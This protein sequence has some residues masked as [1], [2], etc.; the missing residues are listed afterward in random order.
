MVH[1]WKACGSNP[2]RVRVPPPPPMRKKTESILSILAKFSLLIFFFLIVYYFYVG[3]GSIPWEGDSIDY[4]IPIAK[5]ILSGHIFNPTQYIYNFMQYC[6]G[7]NEIILSIFMFLKVPINIYNVV[8]LVV[9]YI[10]LKRLAKAFGLNK[11]IGTIFA[12]SI[13]ISHGVIRWV[14]AQTID[15]WMSTFFVLTLTLLQNPKKTLKYFL[16][17]G[18]TSGMLFGSKYTAP[19]YT[20]FLFLIFGRK[21]LKTI[22]FKN[23]IVFLLPFFTFGFSWYLRNYILTGDPYFPQSIPFFAGIPW[24]ILDEPVWKMLLRFPKVW[25]DAFISEYTIWAPALIAAPI[26]AFK[27]KNK[28]DIKL[29]ILGLLIFAIYFFLPSGPFPNLITSGFRYTYAAFIP[30]ILVLFINAQR[31]NKEVILAVIAIANLLVMPELSY[32]PKLLI[33]LIPIALLIYK[34]DLFHQKLKA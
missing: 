7:A 13:V 14:L 15:I 10:S 33:F 16:L 34:E 19:A 5:L 8:G 4:H 26:L 31:F 32:H 25:F 11:N 24:H 6:P 3:I 18:F 1:A 29:V 2:S 27:H 22:N 9:L 21:L 12:V 17:L 20:L 23:I 30:F 28:L